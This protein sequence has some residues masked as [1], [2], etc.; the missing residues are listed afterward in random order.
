[1]YTGQTAEFW[2]CTK[3]KARYN[4]ILSKF[5][6]CPKG[7]WNEQYHNPPTPKNLVLFSIQFNSPHFKS[8]I[9][10]DN[11]RS[12]VKLDNIL[13]YFFKKEKMKWDENETLCWIMIWGWMTWK[14]SLAF[15]NDDG[16]NCTKKKQSTNLFTKKNKKIKTAIFFPSRLHP[17]DLV[18][19][20]FPEMKIKKLQQFFNY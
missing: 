7:W 4:S 11:R 17:S 8:D 6:N 13:F 18:H 16:K 19:V 5:C 1:M 9:C 20:T 10:K 15:N 2:F 12:H 14:R 3:N